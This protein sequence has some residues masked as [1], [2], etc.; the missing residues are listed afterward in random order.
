[1][2]GS[3]PNPDPNPT[4]G[5]AVDGSNP[6]PNPTP[7]PG[8]AVDGSL[9]LGLPTYDRFTGGGLTV[10]DGEEESEVFELPIA[11][12]DVCL[13]GPRVW[14]QSNPVLSGVRWVI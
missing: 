1:M 5:A 9:V 2:D 12:G 10:W 11:C 14:H 6:N 8:A 7:T 3:N 4:P 13:L